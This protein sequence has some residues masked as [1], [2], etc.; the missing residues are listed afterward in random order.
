MKI[1]KY[2]D[3]LYGSFEYAV[4]FCPKC[5]DMELFQFKNDRWK[6]TKCEKNCI[7]NKYRRKND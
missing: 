6:C 4:K 1:E 3:I 5:R 2:S 7:K